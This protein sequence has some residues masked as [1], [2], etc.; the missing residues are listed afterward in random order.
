MPTYGVKLMQLIP[1]GE[2]KLRELYKDRAQALNGVVSLSKIYTSAKHV[3]FKCILFIH[4]SL[5]VF[6]A[7]LRRASKSNTLTQ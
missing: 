4:L 5:N 2:N 7:V 1:F 6:A 3:T